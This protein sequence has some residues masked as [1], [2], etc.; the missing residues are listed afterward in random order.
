MNEYD[1]GICAMVIVG[2]LLL[3]QGLCNLWTVLTGQ[4]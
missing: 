4:P 1:K 3:A 2:L